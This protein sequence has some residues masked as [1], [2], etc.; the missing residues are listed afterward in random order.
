MLSTLPEPQLGAFTALLGVYGVSEMLLGAHMRAGQTDRID[1]RGTSQLF[2]TVL[3]LSYVLAIVSEEQSWASVASSAGAWAG[4]ALMLAGQLLRW[5]S[6]TTLGRLFTVNVAIRP[7][8]R[9]ITTGPYRYL[10]HPSYAA[11]LLLHLGA[12]L[13]LGNLISLLLL[14]VPITLVLLRRIQVE[15][16]VI[17]AALGPA[18]SEYAA[19]TWRLIP[20]VY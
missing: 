14:T 12:G 19:R 2:R 4:L 11:L 18:Y 9:V 10:R 16:D 8:H 5:W 1:D 17:S 7:Q 15:E 13:C 6:V 20:G 3:P